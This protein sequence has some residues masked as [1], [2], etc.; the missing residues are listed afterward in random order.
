MV[1]NVK[2]GKNM[3]SVSIVG[4]GATPFFNGVK[5]KVNSPIGFYQTDD[6]SDHLRTGN[7]LDMLHWMQ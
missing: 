7:S 2:L 1:H 3:R 4:I 6:T 5:N